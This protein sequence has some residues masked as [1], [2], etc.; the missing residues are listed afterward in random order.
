MQFLLAVSEHYGDSYLTHIML[1]VFLTAIGEDAQLTYFP[2]SSHSKIEGSKKQILLKCIHILV[3]TLI[4]SVK[5]GL[6]PRTAV[7][8]RLA[9]MCILPLF[10]AGVLG[11]PSKHEQLVE[12]LRKLLVEGAGNQ[13]TKCN[14]EIVDAVRFL[15]LVI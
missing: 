15:W 6:A 5:T 11:A 1:P 14:T 2:S 10:L 4:V 9:T 13:S 8:K 3:P 7:A 12:Y